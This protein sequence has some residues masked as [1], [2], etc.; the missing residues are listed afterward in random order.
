MGCDQELYAIVAMHQLLSGFLVNG[1]S[2]ER[3]VNHV[4][5]P[6]IGV[7]MR[8]TGDC[9]QIWHLPYGWR[10]SLKTSARRPSDSSYPTIHRLKW[11]SLPPNEVGR[12]AQHVSKGEGRKGQV[13]LIRS[14]NKHPAQLLGEV[15][16]FKQTCNKRRVLMI[17]ESEIELRLTLNFV[18]V[19]NMVLF[20]TF[21]VK[22]MFAI[23]FNVVFICTWI[24]LHIIHSRLKLWNALLLEI[25]K[26]L[27]AIGF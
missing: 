11:G 10:K 23:I 8:W 1:H 21:R 20:P 6:V 27:P 22:Q 12:I 9:A 4:C 14:L 25:L 19:C 16:N 15:S 24:K 26:I 2:P 13:G 5:R 3:H 17:R 18:S 7:I